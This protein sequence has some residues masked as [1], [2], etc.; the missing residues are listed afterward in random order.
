VKSSEVKGL[1]EE[2]EKIEVAANAEDHWLKTEY[3]YIY[4]TSHADVDVGD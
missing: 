4:N 2:L 1:H 3:I